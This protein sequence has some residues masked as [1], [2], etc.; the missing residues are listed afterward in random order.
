MAV[1]GAS[2]TAR[3]ARAP[4]RMGWALPW[5]KLAAA[6]PL[7]WRWAARSAA[8]PGPR[9]PSEGLFA[10]L[11]LN[12]MLWYGL[13]L[14]AS[15][16]VVGVALYVSLRE[17]LLE[18]AR[19]FAQ[20]QAAFHAALWEQGR[21]GICLGSGGAPPGAGGGPITS[22]RAGPAFANEPGVPQ[23]PS[24]PASGYIACLDPAGHVVAATR[25]PRGGGGV[26]ETFV[27][28]NL[29]A[30]ALR[31]GSASD[32][33]P[34][35]GA[36]DEIFRRAVVAR[37][38]Q[39]GRVVGVV[40]AGRHVGSALDTLRLV[41]NLMLGL[42]VFG[43]AMAAGGGWFLAA[44][45]LAPARLAFARQQAFIADA[46]HELR[47]PI[48]LM[49]ANA[50]VLLR[51]RDRLPPEDAEVLD[52]I[53]AETDHMGRLATD[54]L[55]LARLDSGRLEL[56]REVVDLGELAGTLAR[57]VAALAEAKGIALTLE[58]IPAAGSGGALALADAE[59]AQQAALVLVEN[60]VKYT[61]RGGS[62][63]LR[64]RAGAAG[65]PRNRR[66]GK[67]GNGHRAVPGSVSLVVEDTGPGIAPEHLRRL[68]ERFYRADASRNRATGGTGLGL[69]IA[70]R[71][72]RAH[73]GAVHFESTP[74]KGTR[75]TLSLPAAPAVPVEM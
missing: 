48:T 17:V 12:L 1:T 64:V 62:V 10:R 56:E 40:V 34:S 61:P 75:A 18:P 6:P 50:E 69:A 4:R 13:A 8:V 54:L 45:A 42:G 55:T 3:A 29:V 57:R 66:A 32:T 9:D 28:P 60:A 52:D 23:P 22:G 36:A 73:G 47:T 25:E 72:A 35:T 74:G 41:R 51:H 68:G 21:P 30:A 70:F 33:T 65:R 37:D 16:A 26:P 67:D 58:T 11:R 49:R 39:S 7:A 46:S 43:L 15:L 19:R 53:V 24:G 2:A 63:A 5:P 38:A 14:V 59:Y 27:N 44:R 20:D 31:H 71:I